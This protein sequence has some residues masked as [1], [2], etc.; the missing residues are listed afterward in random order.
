MADNVVEDILNGVI[1]VAIKSVAPENSEEGTNSDEVSIE[2]DDEEEDFKKYIEKKSCRYC[3]VTYANTKVRNEHEKK[4][5][6]KQ[7]LFPCNKCGK[8]FT[9]S[10][11]MKYHMN[12]TCEIKKFK[13][14][15]C[16]LELET[17]S[18]YLR[19]RRVEAGKEDLLPD[20]EG[21]KCNLKISRQNMKRH[22]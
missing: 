13:C 21:D 7:L 11:S 17:Y 14:K 20:L 12:T 3:H 9:N 8:Q 1:E 16:E 4:V 19:H 22:K 5:H 6:L 18:E 10:T 2:S 15:K